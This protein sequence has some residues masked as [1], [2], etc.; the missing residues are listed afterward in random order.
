MD[1]YEFEHIVSEDR[2]QR[3]LQACNGDESMAMTLYCCNISASIEMFAVIGAFEVALRNS[4]NKIMIEKYGNDWLRDAI[5]AGGIFDKDQCRDHAKIIRSAYDKLV[6]Q[7][8]YTHTHL[9]SKMEFG[10]WKYMFSSPQ[11]RASDRVLLKIFPNKT[12]TTRNMQYNNTYIFN[13]LDHINSMRNRIAHH[14][15]ICFP[16]GHAAITASYIEYIYG[17]IKVLFDWLG[18]DMREYLSD[19]DHVRSACD[20]LDNLK[21]QL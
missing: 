20:K 7:G 15:P 9:L 16:T 3:Y 19:I 11:Y 13:E 4:I 2:L 8:R 21:R 6:K 12:A 18:V 5:L 14:E 10:I 17:K 1:F